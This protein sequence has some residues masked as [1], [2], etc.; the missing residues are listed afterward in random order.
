[1]RRSTRVHVA[2]VA[3]AGVLAAAMIP[4][5]GAGAAHAADAATSV[6]Y[7][8]QVAVGT[9]V[10][11]GN[12]ADANAAADVAAIRPAEPAVASTEQPVDVST[13]TATPSGA[14]VIETESHQAQ[15]E[16]TR[17]D[18]DDTADMSDP[19]DTSVAVLGT[20]IG[21]DTTSA[22][23]ETGPSSITPQ[24]LVALGLIAVGAVA[25]FA[26]SLARSGRRH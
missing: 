11:I 22:L 21:S 17:V 15:D 7:A 3:A 20:K 5:L 23:A 25:R 18:S 14:I 19:V 26:P 4:M 10:K 16:P 24:L 9:A 1:M 2:K 8:E 6:P 12:P 13:V